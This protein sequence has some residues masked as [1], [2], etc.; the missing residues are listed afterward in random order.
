MTFANFSALSSSIERSWEGNGAGLIGT[1]AS[2][3][4]DLRGLTGQTGLSFIW[5]GNGNDTIFAANFDSKL[6]GGAGNDHL[7]SGAGA[8]FSPADPEGTFSPLIADSERT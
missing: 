6:Y 2:N 1:N 7:I 3:V 5:G 4:F 8:T